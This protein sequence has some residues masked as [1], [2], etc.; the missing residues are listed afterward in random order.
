MTKMNRTKKDSNTVVHLLKSTE[1][2]KEKFDDIRSFLQETPGPISFVYHELQNHSF[3][4]E[5]VD[6]PDRKTF[7]HASNRTGIMSLSEDMDSFPEKSKV[8]KW[9][10]LIECCKKQRENLQIDPNELVILLT[11]YPNDFNWFSGANVESDTNDSLRDFFVQ[12]TDWNYYFGRSIDNRFP[13]VYEI[14]SCIFRALLFDNFEHMKANLHMDSKGCIMDF[15]EDKS[16]IILKM[17]TADICPTCYEKIYAKELEPT[18]LTQLSETLENIRKWT[19]FKYRISQVFGIMSLEISGWNKRITLPEAGNLELRLNPKER[20][21]Y[22]LFLKHPEGIRINELFEYRDE[23]EQLYR[24]TTS[25]S[26][27]VTIQ[28]AIDLLT[29]ARENNINEV[30]SRIN[31]KINLAFGKI[32]AIKYGITGKRGEPKRILLDREFVKW[33]D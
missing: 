17:R 21:V 13:I 11:N 5:T 10:D 3:T 19:S 23:L 22:L 28:T 27:N 26:D 16:A 7:T 6:W 25:S 20:A 14:Y 31:A 8:V 12:T 30:L 4:F 32:Y 33:K 15:C 29:D 1:F 9:K 18:F 2:N 24:R